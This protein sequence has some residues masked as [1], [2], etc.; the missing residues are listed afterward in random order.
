M[1]HSTVTV[2]LPAGNV[3]GVVNGRKSARW[4]WSD[5]QP[6]CIAIALAVGERSETVEVVS[7]HITSTAFQVARSVAHGERGNR[8][9]RSPRSASLTRCSGRK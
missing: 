8:Y 5:R 6:E 7:P 3:L 9:G 1:L 2:L 4:F